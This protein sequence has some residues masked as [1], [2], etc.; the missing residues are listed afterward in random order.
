MFIAQGGAYFQK[1]HKALKYIY[2]SISAF[3]QQ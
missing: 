3:L 2:L 1:K